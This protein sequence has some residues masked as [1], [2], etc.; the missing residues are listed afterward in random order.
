MTTR[1]I[2]IHMKYP[3]I[4]ALF[5]KEV[6]ISLDEALVFFYNSE[7]RKKMENMV[8]DIHCRSRIYLADELLIEFQKTKKS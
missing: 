4:I 5:A 3:D 7:L 1:Q 6:N 8:G 2:L